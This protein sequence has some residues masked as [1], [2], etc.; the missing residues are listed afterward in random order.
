MLSGLARESRRRFLYRVPACSHRLSGDPV[1]SHFAR[2]PLGDGVEDD[3]QSL[4]RAYLVG[5][6]APLFDGILGQMGIEM[7]AIAGGGA[8]H[9]VVV[10][11][12]PV[13]VRGDHEPVLVAGDPAREFHAELVHL[14]RG[15]GVVRAE[16]Q[17]DVVG[18]PAVFQDAFGESSLSRSMGSA[19]ASQSVPV[20]S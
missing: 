5:D 12:V 18:Q 10:Q 3:V 6:D 2:D 14:L 19:N 13:G 20:R 16:A 15:H 8:H 7:I 11:V 1:V 4:P 9:D 17:L